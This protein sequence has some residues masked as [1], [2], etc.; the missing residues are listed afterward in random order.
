VTSEGT[1][2]D[3]VVDAACDGVDWEESNGG[4]GRKLHEPGARLETS[5]KISDMSLC[6]TAVS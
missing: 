1:S 5:V 3:G 6:C 4:N 2:L